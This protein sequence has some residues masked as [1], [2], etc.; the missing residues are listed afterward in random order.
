M[1]AI[2]TQ[3][4]IEGVPT[5]HDRRHT[6]GR[7]LRG[8][9]VWNT[10]AINHMLRNETYVGRLQWNKRK[11]IGTTSRKRDRREWIT[12]QVPAIISDEVFQ[13]TQQKIDRNKVLSRR[14]R[15][16][17]YL[18]LAGR[19]RCGRCGA[20]MSG[21]SSHE[22]RRYR[23]LSQV[24]HPSPAQTFCRGQVL[25]DDI[26]GPSWEAVEGV[27]RNPSLILQELQRHQEASIET[28]RDAK[29][30]RQVIERAMHTLDRELRQWEHAYA[31]E[32]ISLEEFRGYKLAIQERRTVLQA[33]EQAIQD[34]LQ[35][36]AAHEAHMETLTTYCQRVHAE[37]Q[38]FDISH[39][40]MALE[41]LDIHVTWTPGQAL[42]I[43]GTIPL[44]DTAS[45]TPWCVW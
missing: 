31:G 34:S 20:A 37:L 44:G 9:G 43:T 28:E 40:R 4:T 10:P 25:A 33:Q 1:R 15:K 21:Y 39:K 13:A 7:K 24:W 5:H 45:N 17:E 12:V 35:A 2:A 30:E 29:R 14:N 41:A 18:F 3:L 8:V 38:T 22:R 26:E 42:Q 32:A 6:T 23:C 36:L 19:L 16:Y 27:L 11:H